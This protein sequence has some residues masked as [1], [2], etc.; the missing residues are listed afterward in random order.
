M[1][2]NSVEKID[3]LVERDRKH[4]TAFRAAVAHAGVPGP[5]GRLAIF[6]EPPGA[7]GGQVLVPAHP[8]D[9]KLDLTITYLFVNHI[10]IS[11]MPQKTPTHNCQFPLYLLHPPSNCP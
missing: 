5:D 8:E 6:V 10:F 7:A 1:T 2:S 9:R 11:Q 4:L 3:P